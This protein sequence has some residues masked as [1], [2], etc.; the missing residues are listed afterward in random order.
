MS[1]TTEIRCASCGRY[2]EGAAYT[3]AGRVM[4][5]HCYGAA[6]A[7]LRQGGEEQLAQR[8]KRIAELEAEN[9]K[10]KARIAELERCILEYVRDNLLLMA[11]D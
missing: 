5:A 7:V 8:D 11:K 3:L 10:L 9:E 2:Y 1:A 4:C 6:T